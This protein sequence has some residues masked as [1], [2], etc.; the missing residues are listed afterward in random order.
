MKIDSFIRIRP[1]LGK[2]IGGS[3]GY[4]VLGDAV[5][6]QDDL[7]GRLP[8][9]EIFDLSST[10]ASIFKTVA[11]PLIDASL[12][13]DKMPVLFVAGPA[14]SGKSFTIE[15][16][17]DEN[18]AAGLIY[19]ALKYILN[20][21]SDKLSLAALAISPLLKS[22]DLLALSFDPV[23]VTIPVDPV[24]TPSVRYDSF[25]R[26]VLQ[27]ADS[28]D[29]IKLGSRQFRRLQRKG[30]W[31]SLWV[32]EYEIKGFH[33]R[34]SVAE[35]NVFPCS[36]RVDLHLKTSLEKVIAGVR[37]YDY[38]KDE[39]LVIDPLLQ[40]L[41]DCFK[42]DRGLLSF[43]LCLSEAT[44]AQDFQMTESLVKQMFGVVESALE[45]SKRLLASRDLTSCVFNM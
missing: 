2:E 20:N 18:C 34:F 15:G 30:I 44:K 27:L 45:R 43:I 39:D 26:P 22:I 8:C 29:L 31:N 19:N 33:G 16:N 6:F 1:F 23:P 14:S 7:V 37:H 21:S 24:L 40:L 12:L 36:L 32:M 42:T 3:R 28:V 38:V 4:Q 35:I 17:P 5:D 13:E 9:S 41:R 10:Q 25:L 11:A